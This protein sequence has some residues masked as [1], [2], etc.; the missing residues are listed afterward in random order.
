MASHDFE[1]VIE[2]ACTDLDI[3]GCAL[4]ATNRDGS[5]TYAKSF[6][7][8]AIGGD[9]LFQVDTVAWIG[10]VHESNSSC[11]KLLTSLAALHLVSTNNLSLDD[12]DLLPKHIPELASK[13]ILLRPGEDGTPR[14]GPRTKPITL[15]HLLTH[16]SGLVYDSM[17]PPMIAWAK[18]NNKDTQRGGT[19]LERFDS[20]LAFEP[21]ASWMYGPG[22]DYA[23]LLVE[24]VSGKTLEEY[25]KTH[26]LGPVGVKDMTF[27]LSKR[28][29]LKERLAPFAY[30]TAGGKVAATPEKPEHVTTPYLD[31]EGNEV[32]GCFG[33]QGLFATAEE[34]IKVLR[35][36]LDGSLIPSSLAED[37]FSPQLNQAQ[38]DAMNELLQIDQANNVMGYT[39]KNVRKNWGLAGLMLDADDH[40]K[41]RTAGTMVW[42]GMPMQQWFVDRKTGL[43]GFFMTQILPTGDQKAAELSGVFVDGVYA[44]VSEGRKENGRL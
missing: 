31:H 41:G 15:R 22:I 39:R 11:T 25:L 44:L 17:T 32:S 40:A 13:S 7:K 10:Y 42:A 37:F 30:R 5:F 27:H 43:C 1:K 28:R 4:L 35:G 3:V 38:A 14:E 20:P 33:G 23:G 6:G 9:E 18:A 26:I 21:G 34:Y 16:T 24:R 19:V 8:A 36:V 2:M 12:P 29:D